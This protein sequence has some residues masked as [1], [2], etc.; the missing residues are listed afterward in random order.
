MSFTY[1]DPTTPNPWNGPG[2]LPGG[3]PQRGGD[4]AGLQKVIIRRNRLQET[5]SASNPTYFPVS[6]VLQGLPIDLNHKMDCPWI[7]E[8][9]Q[10]LAGD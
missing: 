1:A 10:R 5:L 6:R 8:G 2:G 4:V 9:S 7:P 3:M